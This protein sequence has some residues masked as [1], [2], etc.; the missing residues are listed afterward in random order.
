VIEVCGYKRALLDFFRWPDDEEP[1]PKRAS[2]LD[3]LLSQYLEHLW[4][5]GG[6]N[7][8]YAGHVL[9]ALRR[10][11]L[12][13]R[14]KLPVSRQSSSNRKSA[15][16]PRQAVP[17]PAEVALALAGV[18]LSVDDRRLALLILLGYIAFLWTGG[19]TSLKVSQ[20]RADP[21]SGPVV[22]ALPATKTS[23]QKLESVA[24]WDRNLAL[25]AQAALGSITADSVGGLTP[26]QFRA[27]LR[28][29]LAFLRLEDLAYTGTV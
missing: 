7:I 9:S 2:V 12:Q 10:F 18:A 29:L 19:I 16:V 5:D 20:I 26:N 8:T 15:H 1:I 25:F 3:D 27:K 6:I 13:L 22:L 21:A 14:F 24:M 11:Y 4:L 17:M 28:L 23:K